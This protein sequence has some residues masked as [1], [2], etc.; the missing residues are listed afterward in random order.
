MSVLDQLATIRRVIDLALSAEHFAPDP[1]AYALLGTMAAHLLS[2]DAHAVPF[3]G[4]AT[5]WKSAA[6]RAEQGLALVALRDIE[7]PGLTGRPAARAVW[8]TLRRY[9]STAW[10]R[11]RRADRR[12]DE[13][14]GRRFDVL[15][16]GELPEESSLPRLFSKIAAANSPLRLPRLPGEDV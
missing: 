12:P 2:D 10:V 3:V 14:N 1:E 5:G 13:E 4:L 9:E 7:F 6:A 8:A 16:R 15:S 11:D